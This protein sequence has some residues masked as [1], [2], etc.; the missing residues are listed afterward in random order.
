MSLYLLAGRFSQ[1]TGLVV[2]ILFGGMWVGSRVPLPLL[3]S[4]SQ[5]FL[6]ANGTPGDMLF[7][8]AIGFL[9]FVGSTIVF[10][11][12]GDVRNSAANGRALRKSGWR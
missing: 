4:M 1:L 11:L 3:S 6:D 12:I 8:G 7:A 5:A 10:A 9:I 2:A